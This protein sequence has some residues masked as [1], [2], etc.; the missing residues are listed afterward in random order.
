VILKA[1][2]M[3]DLFRGIDDAPSI[4]ALV[5][6]LIFI[7]TLPSLIA[8]IR[9]HPNLKAVVFVNLI[10]G[11]SIL[12]WGAVLIWAFYRPNG[13]IPVRVRQILSKYKM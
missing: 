5:I 13:T 7:Y 12:A 4:I 3:Q 9:R 11:W 10:F 1:V 8:L 6:V 2:L